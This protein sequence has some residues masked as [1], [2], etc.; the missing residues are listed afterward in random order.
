MNESANAPIEPA[1]EGYRFAPVHVD[2]RRL[3]VT[4]DGKPVEIEPKPLALLLALAEANGEVIGKQAL[5]ERL[6]PRQVVTDAVLNQ[7]VLR[8]RQA[9]GDIGHRAIVTVHRHGYRLGLPVER[10]A[11]G[12]QSEASVTATTVQPTAHPARLWRGLA[13]AL[14][15]LLIVAGGASWLARS[16][17]P[18]AASIA[19]MPIEMRDGNAEDERIASGF[20]DALLTRLAQQADLHVPARTSVAVAAEHRGDIRRIGRELRVEHVVEAVLRPE[21]DGYVLHASIVRTSD[22]FQQ[23]ARRFDIPPGGLAA[24]EMTV[25]RA[26]A[27]ALSVEATGIA[28][29]SPVGI[30]SE[31]AYKAFLDA[32]ALRNQRTEASLRWA[33]ER[34]SEALR[35]DGDFAAAHAGL[36]SAW[37]LLYEYS[38][39]SLSEAQRAAQAHIDHALRLSPDLAEAHAAVGLLKLNAG[40]GRGAENALRRAVA[41][42]RGNATTMMWLGTALTYQGRLGEARA[43]HEQ[44]LALDP[45]SAIAETYVGIDLALALD[46]RAATHFDNARA[47]DP[48]LVE[49]LWQHALF[50]RLR[51]N[52][53]AA[54]V[55][56]EKALA[57]D[58]SSEYTRALLAATKLAVGAVDDAARVLGAG[59]DGSLAIWLRAAI[60]VADARGDTARTQALY[61]LSIDRPAAHPQDRLLAA[62]ASARTGGRADSLRRFE[63]HVE[64]SGDNEP[65]VDLSQADLGVPDLLLYLQLMRDARGS[66]AA[67]VAAIAA[68]QR[69][70]AMSANGVRVPALGDAVK[71]VATFIDPATSPGQ[72]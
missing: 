2:A 19:V 39:L 69:L 52:E 66:D 13:P 59:S 63:Q 15:A 46:A 10:I 68:R 40:D 62:V 18:A 43:W 65:F 61:R 12:K 71:Q 51:G 14:A 36:A 8:A 49:P 57:I 38:N 56:L 60:A 54:A 47:I 50:E 7:C 9:L 64:A 53:A 22:G 33:I 35:I 28:T 41:L 44:A 24:A 11:A 55:H 37:L 25:V 70:L 72:R 34:Y 4:V 3:A 30:D 1:C 5:L 26:I 48:R 58:S 45:L 17:P 67:R 6:W 42:E 20:G 27:D 31:S 29:D 23:W 16:P 32:N 21:Q